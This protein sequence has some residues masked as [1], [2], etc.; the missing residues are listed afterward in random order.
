[1]KK[2]VVVIRDTE[3]AGGLGSV[4]FKGKDLKMIDAASSLDFV[5]N[6]ILIV[7]DGNEQLAVFNDW[8]YWKKVE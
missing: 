1:M 6:K 4:E 5:P 2:V 3:V 8:L 7:K